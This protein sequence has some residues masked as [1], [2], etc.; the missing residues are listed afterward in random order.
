MP[1]SITEALSLERAGVVG[2]Q[3]LKEDE[4]VPLGTTGQP[5]GLEPGGLAVAGLPPAGPLRVVSA[6]PDQEIS[7]TGTTFD[8]TPLR[9]AAD[10]ARP[11]WC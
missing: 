6:W 7:E 5:L 10:N 8:T 3:R 2:A 4:A 1:S 9:T 11:L